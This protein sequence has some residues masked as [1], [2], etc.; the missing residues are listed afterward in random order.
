MPR[1]R[2]DKVSQPGVD[3]DLGLAAVDVSY[4]GR[5]VGKLAAT[6]SGPLAFEY[7]SE[8]LV[9]GFSIS[10]L[11]LPLKP[12]VL[13]AKPEPLDGVFGVFDDSLP[14]GWGRLLVDRMLRANGIEPRIVGP[15][16]RL[17]IVGASGMGALEYA[18]R[19]NLPREELP[20]DFDAIAA[21]CTKVLQSEPTADAELD[22]LFA[23]GGSSGGARPKALLLLDGASW[24]VKFPSSHD[25]VDIGKQEFSYAEV[26]RKCGLV[27]P[28]TRLLP[29][30]VCQGYFGVRRFD[31][32]PRAN[33]GEAKTHMVSAG[34]LLE[35]SHRI[36]N[37]DYD[38]LMRLTLMLTDSPHDAEALFRLMCFNVFAGNRDDHAKNFS[39]L[40][41]EGD[42]S[43]HLSPAYDLTES[44]GT[45]GERAT[46]VNGKG[47]G[48]G[49]D[50]L[51]AVGRTGGLGA[52]QSR[53]I[54]QEIRE[55]V[56]VELGVEND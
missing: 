32:A 23:L 42:K 28:E 25:S 19:F 3:L 24:I 1:G 11:S 21:E 43:W 41:N 50:D 29:S 4:K 48:I 33:G 18:P 35:T 55:I 53:A 5:P 34:G 52:R 26:A 49:L 13:V 6:P 51:V 22:A 31:R 9:E 10:P 47:K 2:A 27:L 40:Y 46:T 16:V 17:A 56:R 14:D 12:G 39:Y 15:L 20:L 36:P 7:S 30:R 45:Y 54:A 37:L 38:I 8:W 44:A